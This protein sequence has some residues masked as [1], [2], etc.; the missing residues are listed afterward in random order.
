MSAPEAKQNEVASVDVE[1]EFEEFKV[2]G[3]W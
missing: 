2:D 1:D 3:A